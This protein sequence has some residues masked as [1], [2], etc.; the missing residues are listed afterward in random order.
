[1]HDHCKRHHHQRTAPTERAERSGATGSR[2]SAACRWPRL[3]RSAP[4][5]RRR[6]RAGRADQ[7]DLAQAC[8]CRCSASSSSSALWA[9]LAPRVETSLGAIP[10][11]AEVW[12][13]AVRAG[14][15]APGRARQGG[16]L[17][18]APGGA[19]RR[20]DRRG[21]G[22]PGQVARIYR[23][24]DLSRPDR[25]QPED[26]RAR[27]PDRDADRRAAR[28]RLRLVADRER[29]AQSADPDL[30]AG[31]AARLAADRHDGGLRALHQRRRTP[32]PNRW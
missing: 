32:C 16:G 17:L 11:P 10:G 30:Q 21:Q 27:L 19:E 1:M 24:A 25:H 22:R 13:Q 5:T 23:P 2:R 31:V 18:R 28:H 14:R 12:D 26:G 3:D 7:G 6:R 15:G 8:W 20:A 9:A 4:E 29:G